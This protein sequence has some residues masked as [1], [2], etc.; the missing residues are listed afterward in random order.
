[1]NGDKLWQAI[2]TELELSLSRPTFKTWFSQT[3]LFDDTIEGDGRILTIACPSAYNKEWLETHYLGQIQLLAESIGKKSTNVVLQVAKKGDAKP[4]ATGPLFTESTVLHHDIDLER[5]REKAQLNT[6]YTFDTFVVGS[7]NNLAYTAG[8]A[9]AKATGRI[10]NPLFLYG[11]V[12]IGKTHLMHAI[13]NA[14]LESNPQ[15]SVLYTSCEQ[16]TNDLIESLKSKTTEK[17]RNKYRKL[18]VLIVDDIQFL[19]RSEYSQE[20]FFNTFNTLHNVNKQIIIASDRL[21]DEIPKLTDRLTSRLQ[22]GLIVDLSPPD[23]EMRIAIISTKGMEFGVKFPTDVAAFIADTYR[24]N[25]RELEGALKRLISV[26][27]A[28][29]QEITLQLTKQ[30]LGLANRELKRRITPRQLVE[31]VSKSYKVSMR[32]L[33]G[34]KRQHGIVQARQVAM[35]LL[36]TRLNLQYERIAE[37]LGGKDHTTIM[38]GVNKVENL[39]END[40]DF[41]GKMDEV[42][43]T[44]GRT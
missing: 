18:D 36:R 6:H 24:G 23:L 38:Y 15:A 12:G 37:V 40:A 33:T 7:S 8:R 27:S 44:V 2:L 20:E 22:G 43:A 13:G 14:I 31:A 41:A 29:G 10:H 16:F 35:Y 28:G 34:P 4:E 1:M 3:K 9:V 21:P 42:L 17:F 25:T 30:T 32:D 39:L 5:V 26:A 11:G 19:S